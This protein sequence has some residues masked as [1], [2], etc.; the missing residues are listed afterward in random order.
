[1][2]DL[3]RNGAQDPVA[4]GDLIERKAE[5]KL[6]AQGN[7]HGAIWAG[8]GM[9]GVIGWAVVVPTFAG[10]MLG[11]YLDRRFPSAHSWTLTLLALGL[12]LGCSYAW[13]WISK[14]NR[15]MHQSAGPLDE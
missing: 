14:E 13:R 15:S 7:R 11:A 8:L 10:A 3:R 1:V 2:D 5:R 9:S 12:V 4:F 6:G